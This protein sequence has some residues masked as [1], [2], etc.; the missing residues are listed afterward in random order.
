[1]PDRWEFALWIVPLLVVATGLSVGIGLSRRRSQRPLGGL[2]FTSIALTTLA[3]LLLFGELV[4][5]LFVV[6]SDGYGIT[7]AGYRWFQVNWWP[8][9][10]LGYRDVEPVEDARPALLI[11]GDSLMAGHGT[12]RVEQR[13][14]AHL[15][16]AL[17]GAW[18]VH[19]A[20]MCGWNTG[21]EIAAVESWPFQVERIVLTYTLTDIETA[22]N[23]AGRTRPDPAIA[24]PPAWAAWVVRKSHLFNWVYWR[25]LRSDF[26]TRYPD[27]LAEMYRTPEV[28]A[29]H[30]TRLG[31]LVD[32]CRAK[33]QDVRFVLWPDHAR[34]EQC[35]GPFAAVA[36]FLASRGVP[37]LDLTG[38]FR[39]AEAPQVTNNRLDEHPNAATQE[40]VARLVARWLKG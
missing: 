2:F 16:A 34:V 36:S 13:F 39:S 38:E 4:F 1:M 9:N 26:G 19:V 6:K 7:R 23:D 32:A 15:H 30:E 11:V 29:A 33:A 12:P 25:G 20:A 21:E 17:D 35:A 18:R 5:G 3:Y 24:P 14:A 31:A 10:S 37:V 40:R 22:A 8:I 28:W 27:F